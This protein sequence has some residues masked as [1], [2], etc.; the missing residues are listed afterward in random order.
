MGEL[1]KLS[2]RGEWASES[3]MHLP[4]VRGWG[5]GAVHALVITDMIGPLELE[6][7]EVLIVSLREG[8]GGAQIR[9]HIHMGLKL[10]GTPTWWA[11][12]YLTTKRVDLGKVR[13]FTSYPNDS[14]TAVTVGNHVVK[15]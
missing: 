1:G 11:D 10:S 2:L 8:G 13:P 5:C 14:N 15:E 9:A 6:R 3:D 4:R 12:E 7:I